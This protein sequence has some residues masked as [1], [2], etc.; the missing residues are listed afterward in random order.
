MPRCRFALVLA[1]AVFAVLATLAAAPA[2]AA[3]MLVPR[4]GSPPIQLRSHRV[5]AVVD[6]GV[7]RTT[8]RQT[9][10]NPHGRA[11]EA[12][13]VFPVPEDA[14][15][16]DLVME[17]GGQRLEGLLA[18]RRTA[19]RA[20]DR[21]VQRRIDPALVEQIGRDTF[22]LSVFP[23][24]PD[25]ETVVEI[26]WI[27]HLPTT[28]GE[29]RYVYPLAGAESAAT[30]LRDLTVSVT[31]RSSVPIEAVS[32]P[33]AGLSTHVVCPHEVRASME[34]G[35]ARLDQD[36][37]VVA[38]VRASEPTVTVR[39]FRGAAG[40]PY[41]AAV[42]TPPDVADADV[43]ARDVTLVLD[44]SGS[45]A[46]EKL[47]QAKASA[48]WL[49]DHLRAKDRVN[50]L[51]F[52][53]V[54]RR[55]FDLPV[56]ANE[57]N[58]SAL[59][60]F[61][62]AAVDA[63]GTAL[64]DAVQAAVA[65]PATPGRV[66]M[67]VL[68]TDGEPTVGE[69]SP[70]K[71][72][73]FAKDGAARGLR[74][75][76]FGVG[77]DVNRTLLEG[78]AQAG[79]GTSETFRP[80]GEIESRLRAFLTRTASPVLA[81]LRLEIGGRAVDDLLPRPMPDLY[82]GEQAVLV[83]RAPLTGEQEVVVRGIVAGKDVEMRRKVTFP[84]APGGAT[85][86]RDLYAHA[87]LAYLERAVRLRAGLSDEAYFAA[88]D[89]GAYSTQ[90]ELVRAIVELSLETGVQCPYTS[91]FAMLPEDRARLDP[92]D[93]AALD[94]ALD[95]AQEK[96][97]EVAGLPPK[98]S[99]VAQVPRPA[100]TSGEEESPPQADA[101]KPVEESDR[102]VEDPVV[103]DVMVSDPNE[104]DDDLP[105]EESLG[106]PRFASDSPFEGPGTKGTIGI[107]G[108][109]G[110]AFG[111][112]KGGHRNLKAGGGGK[113]T[114]TA[115]DLAL[116]WL[117]NHQSADGRWDSDGYPAQCK[118]NVCE[119]SGAAEGDVGATGLALLCFLGAGETHQSGNHKETVKEGLKY[120]RRVQDSEGCFGPR[121]SPRWMFDHLAACLAMTEAY[122]MT[123]SVIFKDA[124]QRGVNFV[125]LCRN[126]Y[127][128][129]GDGVRPG[130][131]DTT[132]TAWA[133]MCLKS[134]I[135][136]EL[137]VDRSAFDGA[138]AWIDRATQTTTGVPLRR[139]PG[140]PAASD[141]AF[142]PTSDT[143]LIASG[144]LVR[145]FS[146]DPAQSPAK[147]VRVVFGADRLLAAMPARDVDTGPTDAQAWYLGSLAAF[148]IGGDAWKRWNE[149]MTKAVADHQ[150]LEEGRD[151]R[152]S[153][154][155]AGPW[156]KQGGRVY[157]TAL[158]CLCM[159][160]YYRYGRV[161]GVR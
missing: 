117:K 106:D 5:T 79:R 77:A 22:R 107:G 109:A 48:R 113:R 145:V 33:T 73:E 13:Y 31:M 105:V 47:T 71:I 24:L 58:L 128:A 10:V 28:G 62:D 160:V 45:M 89:R 15:L 9:F 137:E 72:V 83:G 90:D 7:A 67:V 65:T 16:V 139:R 6:D 66:A 140:R 118:L 91:F 82:L 151:E 17:V 38:K 150:R 40:D 136:S 146:T 37:V 26:T 34:R 149:A 29:V 134:A 61:V 81:N 68:L 147:D 70:A 86:V 159:E 119:G 18:E 55:C 101:M 32:T 158:N 156:A 125:H 12:V 69:T 64:G 2:R 108:G 138:V 41:F 126:P 121:T 152:G 116:E 100:A 87:R 25:Q 30:T 129:W 3:G 50:V 112:R 43:L 46:G 115:V 1:V 154:D 49:L 131:D 123:Q 130:F 120:L 155:P 110:G 60:V 103:G 122:G 19:R 59:R 42:V 44:T 14:A 144:I 141:D 39:T 97:R 74:T 95:R 142:P 54:V 52:S 99:P 84:A 92:H 4:D 57:K 56:D 27:Q 93:A 36:V 96:R 20:Y 161:F 85:V 132:V 78:V 102:V 114:Q 94:A 23:V 21:L 51:L 111:G 104:T 135:L 98:A 148:Q 75:F 35:G 127:G 88:L 63:G 53:D 8:V 80:Q 133:V 124:A 11:L 143:T 76:A 153:W 157:A